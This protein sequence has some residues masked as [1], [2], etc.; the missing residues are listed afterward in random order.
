MR[1]SVRRLTVLKLGAIAS[2]AVFAVW[3][4]TGVD[5]SHGSAP[6]GVGDAAG[7][8]ATAAGQATRRWQLTLAPAPDDLALAQ[9]SFTRGNGAR[10]APQSL[11]VA[12]EGPFG[13]DYMVAAASSL[14][15]GAERAFVLLVNRPSALLDPVSVDLSLI[16]RRSLGEPAVR[17]L[18]DPFA[19]TEAS[20]KPALCELSLHGAP[21]RATELTVVGS[22]G[23][24]LAG[25]SAASALAQ[26]YDVACGLAYSSAFARAVAP[27]PSPAPPVGKVPGEGCAPTPGRACPLAIEGSRSGA[28]T[29]PASADAH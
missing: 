27:Q 12:V 10:L 29:R 23:A 16:A 6:S 1:R 14:P 20:G 11:R 5:A 9:V 15:A 22:R 18:A 24:P 13:D 7:S 21:L 4:L 2:L 17:T 26:A 19:R 28:G 25:F 8:R 3:A